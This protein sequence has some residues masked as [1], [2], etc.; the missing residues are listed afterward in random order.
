MRFFVIIPTYNEKGNIDRVIEKLFTVFD[1]ITDQ[2][3]NILVTDANSPDGTSE[4]VKELQGKHKNLHLIVEKTKRGLGAAYADA[5][6]HVFSNLNGDAVITFDADLS[7]DENVIPQMI[8]KVLNGSKHVVAS[9]YKK[10]GGVPKEW[11]IH[12]KILSYGGNLFARIIYFN[13]GLTDFTSGF[14][15]MTKDV[16]KAVQHRIKDLNGYTFTIATNIEPVRAGFIPHEIPFYFK[17]R[18]L[19][20][21]KMTS[22][23]FFNAFKFITLLRIQDFLNSRFGKVFMA[24]GTGA[25]S[26]FIVYYLFH[27]LVEVNNILGLP[28]YSNIVGADLFPRYLVAQFLSIEVGLTISFLVNNLWAFSDNKLS[29]FSLLKGYGKNHVV[30]SGGIVIQLVIGQVLA[31]L[32]GVEHVILKY[33]YQGVGILVGLLWNFYFYKKFIWKVK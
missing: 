6:D 30:V 10:G 19:G 14:K 22:E 33:V 9:R 15:L 8:D 7:H 13:F 5:M 29:G 27:D 16:F 20:S 3:M 1:K 17:D 32:F 2:D 28:V 21:S 18:T 25:A 11:A 31:A 24:G 12:R 26:Q 4:I 23:Y